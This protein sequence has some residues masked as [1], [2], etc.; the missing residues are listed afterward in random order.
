[1]SMAD[2]AATLIAASAGIYV[3]GRAVCLRVWMR[4]AK[5]FSFQ[6]AG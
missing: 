2:T 6:F 3:A 1:M 4:D 5:L